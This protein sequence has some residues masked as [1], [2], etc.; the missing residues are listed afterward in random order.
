VSAGA[1]ISLETAI[2]EY[3]AAI[4]TKAPRTQQ[5]YG[6]ILGEL[7]SAFPDSH[8]SDF[9]AP[10][11]TTLVINLL[12]ER[13]GQLAPRSYNRS[14]SVFREF[15]AWH[16]AR[17]HLEEDPGKSLERR[18]V[19]RESR[20]VFTREQVNAILHSNA[21]PRDAVPLR[22]LFLLGMQKEPL[23]Q[24]R[25]GDFDASQTELSFTRGG[26]RH[27]LQIEDPLLWSDLEK[28]RTVRHAGEEDYVVPEEDARRYTPSR[29]ELETMETVGAL[30]GGRRYLRQKPIG[31]WERATIESKRPRGTHGMQKWWYRC[32]ARAG[33]VEPGTETGLP[34][35]TARNT[36]GRNLR[37]EGGLK[38]VM[39]VLA[40]SS[41]GSA[42][43]I[44]SNRDADQ[45]ETTIRR[46]RRQLRSGSPATAESA[47]SRENRA[48]SQNWWKSPIARLIDYIAEERDLV[49]L[50]RVSIEVLRSQNPDSRALRDAA[51]TLTRVVDGSD[52][53]ARAQE[54]S[55]D[56]HPL[57]HG[58]S[59]VAIWGAM[60]TMAIDVVTAWVQH[61]PAVRMEEHIAEIKVPYSLFETLTA[62]ERAEFL[63][64]EL[65]S[66]RATRIGIDRFE[67]LL[68]A[69][70][71][72]GTRDRILGRNIYEMQQIRNVF[73]HKR[74]IADRRF[75]DACPQ[76]NYVAG[77][78]ILI[79]R[80]TWSDFM[81]NALVYAEIVLRRMKEQV[82]MTVRGRP[83]AVRPIRYVRS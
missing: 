54:E 48:D 21:D 47:H 72:S 56:D 67:A 30:D 38:A 80:N 35:S 31:G 3:L 15:L 5:G 8:L 12:D 28:L 69:V 75:V 76:L 68:D 36:V 55:S 63:V 19:N 43:E 42:G 83:T 26:R 77:E 57:L 49:E 53:V 7:A 60:E 81:V 74:G 44:Y 73:A 58:H 51:A 66:K 64:R 37:A 20:T 14:V 61:Q 32:M 18:P 41:D 2:E 34:M 24:L 27:A 17:G 11:G 71:L 23:R 33:M 59:S 79:D 39:K 16:A 9:E 13:W 10:D 52:L 29:A 46:L 82:G 4:A 45:L 1:D 78:T 22:L 70:G 50:S 25:F 62:E 6:S 40:L 65:D